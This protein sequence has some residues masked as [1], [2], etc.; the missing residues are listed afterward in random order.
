MKKPKTK[1]DEY[2]EIFA[3]LHDYQRHG[4]NTMIM[5]LMRYLRK[6]ADYMA[7][8]IDLVAERSGVSPTG[9]IT[10]TNVEVMLPIVSA[11]IQIDEGIEPRHKDLQEA[12]DIFIEEYRHHKI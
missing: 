12:W 6:R 9:R 1:V 10:T 5:L 4:A 3:K 8:Y 7:S 11:M 2:R